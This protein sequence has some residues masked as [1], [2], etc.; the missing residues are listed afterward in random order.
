MRVIIEIQGF[1]VNSGAFYPKEVCVTNLGR[2]CFIGHWVLSAP[3]LLSELTAARRQENR[4]LTDFHHGIQWHEGDTSLQYVLTELRRISETADVIYTR[5]SIKAIYL[6][7]ILSRDI[8]NLEECNECPPFAELPLA[9]TVCNV[10]GAVP[11]S[12]VKN[13]R[14][15]LAS[16]LQLKEWLEADPFDDI[17]RNHQTKV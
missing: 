6:Q 4:W 11:S 3:H 16:A 7:N 15:A 1:K 10:H 17:F 12:K 14:C 5:G 13:K 9:R 8:I 2:D